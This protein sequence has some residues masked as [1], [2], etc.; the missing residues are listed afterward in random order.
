MTPR[1]WKAILAFST[2]L[3]FCFTNC[4]AEE[5]KGQFWEANV[6]TDSLKPTHYAPQIPDRYMIFGEEVDLTNCLLRERFDR[7]LM[8]FAYWHSQV[9][10]IIKRANKY[11]PVIEPILKEEGVPDDFKYLALIES[12]LDQRALSP[13]KAAGMWQILPTTA[14]EN[15]LIV[16]EEIDERYNLQKATRIACQFL[17]RTYELTQSWSLAA[18]SYNCG[19]ARVL[20][21]METQK[22]SN[23]FEMLFGEETNRYVFRIMLAKFVMENPQKFGFLLK[24]SDLYNELECDVVQVDTMVSN[25]TDFAKEHNINYQILKEANPWLRTNRI[26]NKERRSF[27]IQIPR[28]CALK[29]DESRIKVHNTQWIVNP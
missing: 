21:Q 15:G 28:Q 11:F 25:L 17:K 18:A 29:F 26:T 6:Y 16:N 3:A 10:L 23:Y 22:T 2:I 12:N 5:A 7:E 4:T 27:Y 1:K 8:S 19:R 9:F 20:R 13:A 24:K 14:Q